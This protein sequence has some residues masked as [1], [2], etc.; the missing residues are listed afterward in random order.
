MNALHNVVVDNADSSVQAADGATEAGE[1]ASSS[2]Q[3]M[4]EAIKDMQSVS[5]MVSNAASEIEELTRRSDEIRNIVAVIREIADQTNL[6]A[7]NAAIEAARA[8]EQGRGFAVVA[9]EVRK[10]AER[11]QSSTG[12]IGDRVSSILQV[13]QQAMQ[14]MNQANAYMRRGCEN[15]VQA[16]KVL[17][18]IIVRSEAVADVLRKL[19][20]SGQ[21]QKQAHAQ[22]I[23]KLRSMRS[24]ITSANGSTA[25]IAEATSRLE[26]EI[27]ALSD[28]ANAFSTGD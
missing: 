24:A 16:D 7:L 9:D 12:E 15:A 19:S 21:S 6:L 22:V 11:T 17:H 14:S 27:R 8:G 1:R 23:E 2:G 18:D 4:S 3:V 28:T 13:T 25:E 10:L 5:S 26:V 20:A